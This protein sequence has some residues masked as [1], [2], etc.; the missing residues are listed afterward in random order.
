M[1]GPSARGY[2]L[3]WP[4]AWSDVLSQ[5]PLASRSWATAADLGDPSTT[6]APVPAAPSALTDALHDRSTFERELGRGRLGSAGIGRRFA[7]AKDALGGRCHRNG[8]ARAQSAA[9]YWTG[10]V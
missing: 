4:A 5:H 2:P 9:G 3:T 6:Q 1:G 8:A 10:E 7:V